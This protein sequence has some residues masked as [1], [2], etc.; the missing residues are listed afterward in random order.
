M[1]NLLIQMKKLNNVKKNKIE[2]NNNNKIY[3]LIKIKKQKQK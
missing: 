2:L 1:E 3:Q